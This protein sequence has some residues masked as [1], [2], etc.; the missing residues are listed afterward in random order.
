MVKVMSTT[1]ELIKKIK[2]LALKLDRSVSLMEV[3]G[4]H[5]VSIFKHGIRTIVPGSVKLLSGPGCPV[6]VTS[7]EDIEKG[8]RIAA[9]PDVIFTT[10]GD[11]MKVPGVT[12][13]L[14]QLKAEGAD[15]RILYSPMDAL[16]LAK[17]HTNKRI[18]F[19]AIGFETTAPAIAATVMTAEY[20]GIENFFIYSVL[21]LIPPALHA[22]LNRE[23]LEVDGF[24]L[25]GHVSAIIGI[26][27]YRFIAEQYGKPGVITGFEAQDILEAV[28]ILLE[29]LLKGAHTIDNQYTRVVQHHGNPKALTVV[30][31]FFELADTPWRGFGVLPS[32]GLRLKPSYKHRDI[33]NLVDLNI[34]VKENQTCLCGDVVCGI[35]TP[36]ECSLF[37]KSCTPENPI[38]PC[39]VSSEGTC[40][41][42]YKYGNPMK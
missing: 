22:L 25:P 17:N 42:Y 12:K 6:C 7:A 2:Y 35:I 30:N 29:N 11:M 24:I 36:P 20:Q 10:F 28:F 39:M 18:V 31:T 19:F 27:P 16:R 37:S 3:C 32:S 1:D 40:A 15:V 9:E 21:K 26:K 14:S 33:T 5:T 13:N 38:G 8:L 34:Q 23:D 4:T 41:A